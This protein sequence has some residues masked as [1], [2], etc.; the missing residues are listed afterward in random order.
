M[1]QYAIGNYLGLHVMT[2]PVALVVWGL[3]FGRVLQPF[4]MDRCP[5]GL[6]EVAPAFAHDASGIAMSE[7]G[8]APRCSN[9]EA[10]H[11]K[12]FMQTPR[13]PLL[14]AHGEG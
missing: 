12:F 10:C 9:T 6:T 2:R 4:A 5:K 1:V 14:S 11:L 13:P 3:E 7:G 8:V